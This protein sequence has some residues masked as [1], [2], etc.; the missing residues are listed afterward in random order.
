MLKIQIKTHLSLMVLVSRFLMLYKNLSINTNSSCTHKIITYIFT[1]KYP[2]H[3]SLQ[4]SS[5]KKV[6]DLNYTWIFFICLC[7][8][9]SLCAEYF[10]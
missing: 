7:F 6:F 8:K 4:V 5:P 2:N 9:A 1:F 10:I 3:C